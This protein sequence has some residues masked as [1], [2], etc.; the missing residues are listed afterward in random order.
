MFFLPISFCNFPYPL[1]AS[2]GKSAA[3]EGGIGYMYYM[4]VCIK[5]AVCSCFYH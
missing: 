3:D 4:Y 2:G 5:Y 1:F